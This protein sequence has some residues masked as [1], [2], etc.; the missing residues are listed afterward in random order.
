MNADKL[1]ILKALENK[2]ITADEAARLM[3][4]LDDPDVKAAMAK[5]SKKPSVPTLVAPEHSEAFSF[6]KHTGSKVPELKIADPIH[7]DELPK[8]KPTTTESAPKTSPPPAKPTPPHGTSA[9]D[10]FGELGRKLSGFMNR[11]E[12][13]LHKFAGTLANAADSLTKAAST[14]TPGATPANPGRAM[15]TGRFPASP[16]AKS[17]GPST[18]RNGAEKLFELTVTEAA[19]DNEL[20]LEGHYGSVTARGYNGDKL[21]VKVLSVPK[22][23]GAAIDLTA[24]GTKYVLR[25]DENDFSHVH[26]D[27]L[28]PARLFK[29]VRL[30]ATNG[31][32]TAAGFTT[33]S[34]DLNALNGK[35]DASDIIAENAVI[36]GANGAMTL[37]NI[38]AAAGAIECTNGPISAV[39]TDIAR[40]KLTSINA[41]IS[42]QIA[43]FRCFGNYDWA[44]ETGN[45]KLSV[46]LP[47]SAALGY[48][49]RAQSAMGS[50]KVW[51]SGLQFSR[52]DVSFAEAESTHYATAAKKIR[53]QLAAS[54]APLEVY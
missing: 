47:S 10:E 3:E 54:N 14:P 20:I 32:L 5:P 2:T 21:S 19:T 29:S 43:D 24:L 48:S 11:V 4:K 36:E 41:P 26:I 6:A 13:S 40:L 1:T 46:A 12:P 52:R 39:D 7:F 9:A 44:V 49:L 38:A 15:P 45:A 25:Y 42:V 35:L 22:H 17:T 16:S 34:L 31:K 33:G 23:G 18:V 27:A 28:V 30:S 50:V 8:A 37:K 53:L 51:T